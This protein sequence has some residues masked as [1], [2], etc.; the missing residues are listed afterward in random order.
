M[1]KYITNKKEE[2]RKRLAV[3][4]YYYLNEHEKKEIKEGNIKSKNVKIGL[5]SPDLKNL[6][7]I[8]P[9]ICLSILYDHRYKISPTKV[10][11]AT[12]VFFRILWLNCLYYFVMTDYDDFY[13]NLYLKLHKGNIKNVIN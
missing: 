1:E 7:I 10:N 3:E 9:T 12:N 13:G 5:F 8:L 6:L 4:S 2:I 11:F